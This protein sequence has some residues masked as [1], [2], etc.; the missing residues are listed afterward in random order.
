[1]KSLFLQDSSVKVKTCAYENRP[2]FFLIPMGLTLQEMETHQ[3][4]ECVYLRQQSWIVWA[5][6]ILVMAW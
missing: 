4:V 1:M 3:E 5:K 6:G 2:F